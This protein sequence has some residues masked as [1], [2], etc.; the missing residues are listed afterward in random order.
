MDRHKRHARG[1][2]HHAVCWSEECLPPEPFDL[3]S[4][5]T[6]GDRSTLQPHIRR[7]L[8]ELEAGNL[9]GSQVE[10][11]RADFDLANEIRAARKTTT[12]LFYAHPD[13]K[14]QEG[15]PVL[16]VLV[17]NKYRQIVRCT[18]VIPCY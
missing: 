7:L 4:L 11:H 10:S 1:I 2:S 5:D 17:Q 6:F 3:S 8:S 9:V 13:A 15:H 12:Y 14:D 16:A 18:V